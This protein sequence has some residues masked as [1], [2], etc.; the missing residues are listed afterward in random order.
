M[1]VL[2]QFLV[3]SFALFATGCATTLKATSAETAKNS[4]DKAFTAFVVT[5]ESLKHETEAIAIVGKKQNFEISTTGP[6]SLETQGA[7][8]FLVELPPDEYKLDGHAFGGRMYHSS[9]FFGTAP[10]FDAE[11]GKITVLPAVNLIQ[12][13]HHVISNNP[14]GTIL[15]DM[16]SVE[17]VKKTFPGR[18]I[19]LGYKK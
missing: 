6:A 19:I 4:K 9:E 3:L 17:Q 11:A 14:V 16:E 15:V 12:S 5:D 10:S 1:P 8:I 13:D 18:G 2:R 7:K